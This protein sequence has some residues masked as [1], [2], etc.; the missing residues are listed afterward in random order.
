MI[1]VIAKDLNKE[2]LPELYRQIF[3]YVH[4]QFSKR[5]DYTTVCALH[6]MIIN[7]D[8]CGMSSPDLIDKTVRIISTS[9]HTLQVERCPVLITKY[10]NILEDIVKLTE[11]KT[12]QLFSYSIFSSIEK[13][14]QSSNVQISRVAMEFLLVA[15]ERLTLAVELHFHSLS[16]CLINQ[17]EGLVQHAASEKD[18]LALILNCEAT[19]I[20]N[21]SEKQS[22]KETARLASLIHQIFTSIIGETQS[23]ILLRNSSAVPSPSLP[24]LFDVKCTEAVPHELIDAIWQPLVRILGPRFSLYPQET[25]QPLLRKRFFEP[26]YEFFQNNTPINTLVLCDTHGHAMASLAL[27]CDK[28]GPYFA[29]HA[30]ECF[31]IALRFLEEDVPLNVTCSIKHVTHLLT[32]SLHCLCPIRCD[33]QFLPQNMRK[34]FPKPPQLSYVARNTF[35][36]LKIS[37]HETELQNYFPLPE[38]PTPPPVSEGH[39]IILVNRVLPVLE[40]LIQNLASPSADIQAGCTALC[41]CLSAVA[42]IISPTALHCAGYVC[43]FGSS[44]MYASIPSNG[45]SADTRLDFISRLVGLTEMSLH[46]MCKML[47]LKHDLRTRLHDTSYE[48]RAQSLATSSF[49][50][51]QQEQHDRNCEIDDM[52][53]SYTR[54]YTGITRAAAS[55][56]QPIW[57]ASSNFIFS[58]LILQRSDISPALQLL[59]DS[60]NSQVQIFA[61][62]Q[63]RILA[64]SMLRDIVEFTGEFIQSL[65]PDILDRLIRFADVQSPAW[66]VE[67]G[68]RKSTFDILGLICCFYPEQMRSKRSYVAH[69]IASEFTL[70][71]SPEE[72]DRIDVGVCHD[73]ATLALLRLWVNY[74]PNRFIRSEQIFALKQLWV[75]QLPLLHDIKA[76][77]ICHHQFLCE[78]NYIDEVILGNGDSTIAFK[79]SSYLHGHK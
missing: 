42:P 16:A 73:I 66:R 64:L 46:H 78:I 61:D 19:L 54:I 43:P 32:S 14:I 25:I 62:E 56:F 50:S 67:H 10:L 24:M 34:T 65:M 53:R 45:T 36:Q 35:K 6:L 49:S 57:D 55:S 31:N 79:V 70:P 17:I 4:T 51:Q 28:M 68:T 13:A 20:E 48:A 76:A 75:E 39:P 30:L 9:L 38:I 69:I 7:P 2:E 1:P 52:I 40:R 18:Y 59:S 3:R 58:L 74:Y 47:R 11:Q 8:I 15:I 44:S 72:K 77:R 41:D 12:L 22:L 63:I 29:P 23:N 60:M 5:M 21:V 27:L 33:S 71:L 26:L 37:K